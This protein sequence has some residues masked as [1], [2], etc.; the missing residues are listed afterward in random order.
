M[1]REQV[2]LSL[3]SQPNSLV[4]PRE[5]ARASGNEIGETLET[6]LKEGRNDTRKTRS[7]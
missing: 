7:G 5:V 6:R 1:Y 3:L 2:L 4:A